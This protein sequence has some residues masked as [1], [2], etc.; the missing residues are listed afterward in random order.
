MASKRKINAKFDFKPFSTR[1]MQ[2]MAWWTNPLYRDKE[3]IIADGSVRAGKTVVMSLGYIV[4]S[5]AEFNGHN[6][7]MA[8]KTIGSY[9]EEHKN[10]IY[11]GLAPAI[12]QS[13]GRYGTSIVTK[14]S[15][16]K[17]V[18]KD[19]TVQQAQTNITIRIN[20]YFTGDPLVQLQVSEQE[21]SQS[22]NVMQKIWNAAVWSEAEVAQMLMSTV[23]MIQN[24]VESLQVSDGNISGTTAVLSAS[25]VLLI[26]SVFVVTIIV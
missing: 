14:S 13:A 24:G 20:F 23:G 19:D 4:W 22:Q 26:V 6:F 3:A 2:V 11:V 7:G 16:S 25:T 9:S 15:Y 1:Q 8:G 21:L 18:E 17:R 5:M 12:L 10:E